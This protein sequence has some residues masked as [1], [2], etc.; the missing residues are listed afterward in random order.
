M[1]DRKL[2]DKAARFGLVSMEIVASVG[3]GALLGN[4]LDGKLKTAPAFLFIFSLCGLIYSTWR[5]IRWVKTEE[6]K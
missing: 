3:G 4:F 5:L 2:L 6:K 1:I